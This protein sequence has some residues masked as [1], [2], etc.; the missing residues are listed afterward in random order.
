MAAP[1]LAPHA[2]NIARDAPR[3]RCSHW[4]MARPRFVVRLPMEASPDRLVGT[5]LSGGRYRV[6]AKL[7]EG[8]M[9]FVYR[10]HDANLDAEVVVKM[11][12]KS[13]LD[14]PEFAE[15]FALEVRALVRLSHPHIV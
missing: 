6:V 15:R 3:P 13:M 2:W 10:A 4:R 5:T 14:D 12:R 7:G 11:P 8:G 9:G 1:M